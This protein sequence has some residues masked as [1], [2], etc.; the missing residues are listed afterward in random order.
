MD[1]LKTMEIFVRVVEAGSLTK[2]GAT[3][4]SPR[5]SITMALNRLE[6]YLGVRLLQRT[7]R[8]ISLTADGEVYYDQCRRILQEIDGV[9]ASL[10]RV[11]AA[12]DGKIRVDMP[13]SIATSVII[14]ALDDFRARYPDIKLKIGANDRRIDLIQEGVDCA[15]RTGPL[16]DSALIGRRIGGFSWIT[17]ASPDYLSGKERPQT[18]EQLS[19]HSLIGYFHGDGGAE[20]WAYGDDSLSLTVPVESHL[21]VNETSSYLSLGVH[22]HGIVRLADYIVRPY[23][24]D[25]RL[26]ELLPDYRPPETPI[27]I[28]FPTARHLSPVVR[29]FV[30][31]SSALF[32][33]KS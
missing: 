12:L 6:E 22:G 2:A 8:S 7:T 30:D 1:R 18:P 26:V 10:R 29:A 27:S 3:L 15:I 20:K 11:D 32:S 4:S 21:S 14:P 28:L 5:S 17:C 33:R 13:V 23:L 16:A 9:E 31:W 25:G 19:V 24:T